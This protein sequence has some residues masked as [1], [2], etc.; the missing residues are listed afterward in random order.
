MGTAGFVFFWGGV[1]I[2]HKKFLVRGMNQRRLEI[3]S[4]S[5]YIYIRG[6]FNRLPDSFVQA[7]KIVV[8][9]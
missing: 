5:I 8:D 9:S 4:S 7:F 6:A 3:N 2:K 1:L